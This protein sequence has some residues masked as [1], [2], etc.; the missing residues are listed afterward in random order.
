MEED[1]YFEDLNPD[2]VDHG[3]VSLKSQDIFGNDEYEIFELLTEIRE[4]QIFD[5]DKCD[6][7]TIEYIAEAYNVTRQY[8]ANII[9]RIDVLKSDEDFSMDNIN[10]DDNIYQV[11]ETDPTSYEDEIEELNK[12]YYSD[13][14]KSCKQYI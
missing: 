13:A 12:A 10:W 1:D 9:W 6:F 7:Y 5:D 14:W 3:T 8:H 4:N 11:D 2:Y